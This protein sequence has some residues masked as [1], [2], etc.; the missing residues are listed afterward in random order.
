MLAT[1]PLRIR[2]WCIQKRPT[3]RS[4]NTKIAFDTPFIYQLLPFSEASSSIS[5]TDRSK[6]SNAHSLTITGVRR[7]EFHPIPLYLEEV[8][9]SQLLSI[10]NL[11]SFMYPY[12]TIQTFMTFIPNTLLQNSVPL[13][14]TILSI[15]NRQDLAKLGYH[16]HFLI[17][18]VVPH[19]NAD[20][21]LYPIHTSDSSM[22]ATSLP[23]QHLLFYV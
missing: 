19:F 1:G 15:Q 20:T 10:T 6:L 4:N 14:P 9:I 8:R 23:L 11:L 13:V 17:E 7:L 12:T 18:L 22:D 21:N 5:V 2:Q 3:R 16:S